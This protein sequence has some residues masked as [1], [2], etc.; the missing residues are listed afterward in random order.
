MAESDYIFTFQLANG[1]EV[2]AAFQNI[3]DLDGCEISLAMYRS[4]L[5]DITREVWE[6]IVGKF[7]GRLLK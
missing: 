2:A 7:S 5:G 6:R 1:E 3:N 4:N